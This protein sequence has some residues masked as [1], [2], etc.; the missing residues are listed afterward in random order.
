M[1]RACQVRCTTAGAQSHRTRTSCS[2]SNTSP[3]LKHCKK[4]QLLNHPRTLETTKDA[5]LHAQS[6]SGSTARETVVRYLV[7]LVVKHGN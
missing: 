4:R 1:I 6:S 3:I 5:F 7:D 2:L